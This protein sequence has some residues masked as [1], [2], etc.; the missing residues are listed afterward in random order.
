MVDPVW[1]C[2]GPKNPDVI[3]IDFDRFSLNDVATVRISDFPTPE[4]LRSVGI[5]EDIV[6]A[7]LVPGLSGKKRN[8]PFFKFGRVSNIPDEPGVIPCGSPLGQACVGA[9][10]G[11]ERVAVIEGS[12]KKFRVVSIEE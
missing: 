5:G 1:A 6:S 11:E 8:Y 7:G 10:V 4:E 12:R 3:P 9:A 2:V